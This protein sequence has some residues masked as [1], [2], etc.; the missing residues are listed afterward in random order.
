MPLLDGFDPDHVH[1]AAAEL[2]AGGLVG[3]PTETVYGL[4]ARADRDTAAA[5]IFRAKGRPGDHPLIVH[6]AEPA[7]APHFAARWPPAAAA[8]AARFWPGPMTLIV[9]RR[10]GVASVAAGGLDTVGLRCPDHPVALALLR[11]AAALGVAGVAGPS[12]NR[13]GRVSPTRAA[14]VVDEFGPDLTVLEGGACREGIESTIVDCS[15]EQ[16]TLLRPGTLARAAIEAA[17]RASVGLPLRD[18]DA[19]APRVSGSLAS[20]YAPTAEVR[21]GDARAIG[22]ALRGLP[23]AGPRPMVGVYSRSA[24]DVRL[25]CLH[26]TMPDDPARVAHELFAVLRAFDDAGVRCLWVEAPPSSAAWDGVR[27]RLLRA[28]ARRDPS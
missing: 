18:R 11:E 13:F 1:R 10:P 15:R 5:A 21:L 26:R 20:H 16:P 6:V 12:A 24:P 14:H 19:L 23:P 8:L 9:Q 27:D 17:L 22:D 25:S 4:G 3:F 28:A 2:A 7:Q